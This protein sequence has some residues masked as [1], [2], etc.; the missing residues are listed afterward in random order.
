MH[1]EEASICRAGIVDRAMPIFGGIIGLTIIHGATK[2]SKLESPYMGIEVKEHAVSK[3]SFIT[4]RID[5]I[6]MMDSDIRIIDA[7][8]KT[9]SRG[10]LEFRQNAVWGTISAQGMN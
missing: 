6:D 2:Y 7:D 9:S 5:N 4:H 10:R 1:P 8:G 3:K